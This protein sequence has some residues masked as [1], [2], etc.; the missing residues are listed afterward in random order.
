MGRTDL[1]HA[2]ETLLQQLDLHIWAEGLLLVRPT[3]SEL[4]FPQK[5]HLVLVGVQLLAQ[6]VVLLPQGLLRRSCREQTVAMTTAPAGPAC[7]GCLLSPALVLLQ[8]L[9]SSSSDISI[10]SSRLIPVTSS[11]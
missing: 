1:L 8:G 11:L 6:G 2:V 9:S 4:F 7:P 10:S 5:L 3:V